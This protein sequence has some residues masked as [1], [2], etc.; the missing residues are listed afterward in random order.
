M[1]ALIAVMETLCGALSAGGAIFIF[2]KNDCTVSF[3]AAALSGLIYLML[4]AGQRISKDYKGAAVLVPYFLVSLA[5]MYVM[6]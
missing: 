3:N 4:F 5:G 2:A 1:L 6:Q